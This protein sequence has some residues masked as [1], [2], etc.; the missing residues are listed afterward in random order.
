MKPFRAI[1]RLKNNRLIRLREELGL[2][3]REAAEKIGIGYHTYWEFEALKRKSFNPQLRK[4]SEAAT[5]IADFHG[6]SCEWLW[7]EEVRAVHAK[8]LMLEANA[9]ELVGLPP[10]VALEQ[11][12][13]T[14][15]LGQLVEK[16]LR[17]REIEVLAQRIA[18]DDPKT[19][20]EIGDQY[21]LQKERVR[22]I[23][24]GALRKLRDPK[25]KGMKSVVLDAG[26]EWLLEWDEQ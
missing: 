15:V 2:T 8:V 22:Q 3:C 6:V 16:V 4:W 19:Y 20:E 26:R 23:E 17:P 13:M 24:S 14:K 25:T 11:F 1:I 5:K 12:E 10:N 9:Q 18:T 21:N 7:P